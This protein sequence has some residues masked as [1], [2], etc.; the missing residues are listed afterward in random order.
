M[1]GDAT[2]SSERRMDCGRVMREEILE[3]YLVGRLSEDD[4]DA[5]EE[6]YFECARCF[7]DLQMLRAVR[8]ELQRAGSGLDARTTRS[9]FG[10]T[11]AAA[12]AAVVVLSVSVVLWMRPQPPSERV[13]NIETQP[14][15]QA[16]PPEKAGSPR[17]AEPPSSP[18][19]PSL[20]QLARVEPPRYEP[21]RL[22][23][24]PSE[25][26]T[27]FQMGMARYQKADYRDAVTHLSA[28]AELEP[29]GAHIRFFLGISHLLS[30]EDQAGIR[31]LQATIALGDSAY[32]ED[33]HFY[34]AKAF[35]RQANIGA[36]ETELK[37]VVQL[38][39]SRSGEARQLLTQLERLRNSIN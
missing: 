26:T 5:F 6:H 7:R 39:E 28:A 4:R 18:A 19:E 24:T 36:A 31:W 29:A 25:A 23:G 34:L 35:L 20:P 32:I 38:R 10:W 30:G 3:G 11:A 22:R 14:Q 13:G 12:M 8:G 33:A 1:S 21:L 15:V 9:F 17:G 37:R 16:Q 2:S 27:R